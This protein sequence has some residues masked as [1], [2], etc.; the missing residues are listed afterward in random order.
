MDTVGVFSENPFWD[1]FKLLA[2]SKPFFSFIGAILVVR[3]GFWEKTTEDKQ[4]LM[5][6]IYYASIDYF[7]ITITIIFTQ[8]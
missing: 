8:P 2:A 3:L 1:I 6:F 4:S 7:S 5:R